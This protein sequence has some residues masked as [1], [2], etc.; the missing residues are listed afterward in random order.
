MSFALH[1]NTRFWLQ[2][3]AFEEVKKIASEDAWD[4]DQFIKM[5]KKDREYIT[6]E[7]GKLWKFLKDTCHKHIAEL[8]DNQDFEYAMDRD[9]AIGKSLTLSWGDSRTMYRCP[10][11]EKIWPMDSKY[12]STPLFCPNSGYR[13][14]NWRDFTD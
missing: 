9:E 11:C 13:E 4:A 14:E 10:K 8:A 12:L 5:L 3:L 2:K 1:A 6:I 7:D